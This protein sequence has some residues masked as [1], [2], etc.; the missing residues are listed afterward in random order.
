[1]A[2]V[3]FYKDHSRLRNNKLVKKNPFKF[4]IF[5]P[6]KPRFRIN[7]SSNFSIFL[8]INFFRRWFTMAKPDVIK[9]SWLLLLT[10]NRSWEESWDRT[11]W[12]LRKWWTKSG[13]RNVLDL[14]RNS[15]KFHHFLE[16][17]KIREIISIFLA[18]F[19][20]N[21]DSLFLFQWFGYISWDDWFL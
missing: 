21:T 2:P 10:A 16:K 1:M 13:I 15:T 18:I 17:Q 9:S 12:W 8:K 6:S 7:F 5:P 19:W 3:S 4:R 20:V 11:W 14:W